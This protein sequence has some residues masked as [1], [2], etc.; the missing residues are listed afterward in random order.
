MRIFISSI[1][2]SLIEPIFG[3][4]GAS[5]PIIY[6]LQNNIWRGHPHNI[7]LELAVSYGYPAAILIFFNITILLIQSS[8]SIFKS[9][10]QNDQYYSFEKAWWVSIFVF[11]ISQLV[12]V[13]YFDG[14][15][16]IVFWLLL[17]G[18]RAII[19]ENIERI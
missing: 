1:K 2:I 9:K 17:A 13:Q 7:F 10:L 15:I 3:I 4:G 6:E 16:S 8:K 11:L 18:L 19:D 5:F 12:D 14:R